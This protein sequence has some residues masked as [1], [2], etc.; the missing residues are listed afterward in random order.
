MST[1]DRPL[2]LGTALTSDG[3]SGRGSAPAPAGTAIAPRRAL[4]VVA[5]IAYT[6][7]WVVGLLVSSSSTDVD[8]SGRQVLASLAGHEG[9]ATAQYLL[10]EGA[11]AAF[12]AVVAT[13]LAGAA[14]RAGARPLGRAAFATGLAAALISLV[15]C[16]MGLYL[17]GVAAPAGNAGAAGALTAWS[18]HLDGVKMFILAALALATAALTRRTRVLPR[19]LGVTGRIAALALACS[20]AGYLFTI[21][22][23]A[24]TA[25]VS[26][27]LLL[28]L[29][30][31]SG[32]A[33]A[34][35]AS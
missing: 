28:I 19:W 11:A 4:P 17:T 1:L 30:T 32:V 27:P 9:A 12:L 15:Q 23:L 13:G 7:S 18:N 24:T 20:G 10:T 14:A 25:Y 5:G 8:S 2:N 3:P 35:R 29:V 16:A 26:L 34:R 21:G 31:G 33:L 22:A 6:A